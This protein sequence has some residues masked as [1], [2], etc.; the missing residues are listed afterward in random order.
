MEGL[1]RK[2]GAAI[3]TRARA[4]VLGFSPSPSLPSP[5]GAF[6]LSYLAYPVPMARLQITRGVRTRAR[7]GAVRG[8][9]RQGT[10]IW[11]LMRV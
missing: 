5:F 4:R 8:L 6:A 2:M 9:M 1:G 11:G 7:A 10:L 3:R